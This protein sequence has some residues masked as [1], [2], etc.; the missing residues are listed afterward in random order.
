M[1]MLQE[2]GCHNIEPVTPTPQLP[3]IME[4]LMIARRRGL[5]LP[6]VY[7]CGG[8]ENP[9]VLKLVE[10]MVDIY[11]PDFKY[12]LEDDA[13]VLFGAKDYTQYALASIREMARQV[14]DTLENGR[15]HSKE[16]FAHSTFSSAGAY[17][18]QPRSIKLDQRAYISFRATKHHVSVY[19]HAF[20]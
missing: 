3:Q 1:M 16:G 15:R 7:N 5:H 9:E 8:Y 12:G 14:G 11:M 13:L 2:N 17:R 10:G 4:A 6:L 20:C 18:E 19:A